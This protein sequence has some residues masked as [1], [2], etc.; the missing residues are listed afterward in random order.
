M[1]TNM[2]YSVLYL[3]DYNKKLNATFNQKVQST[4]LNSMLFLKVYFRHYSLVR[5]TLVRENFKEMI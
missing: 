4:F 1:L 5:V 3:N 2:R